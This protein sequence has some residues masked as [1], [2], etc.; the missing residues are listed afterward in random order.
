MIKFDILNRWTSEVQFTAEIECAE[1]ALRSVKI[2]LA[3]IWAVKS[4][5]NLYGANLSGA[6]LSRANLYGANLY[7]ANLY[8]ADLS[9]ANLS[10]ANLSRANLSRAN[11]YGANLSGA[12]LSGADLSRANLYGANLSRANLSR[13]N[14]YGA[15]LYGADLSGADLSRANL[16]G[17]DL[18]RAD[19][20][21]A[22]L[23]G[24]DL[25]RAGLYGADL[26]GAANAALAIAR[27]RILPEGDLIGWKKCKNNI[28]V[29]LR[30]P[31][32]ARRSH[33]FGRKCRAE[34]ADV[35]EVFGGEKGISLHDGKTEY[36]A[37]QRVK[38]DAFDDNWQ[39]E[40]SGGI[41]FYITKEEAEAHI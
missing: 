8:G 25:S 1:D 28:V 41:H 5:A 22:N 31:S 23:Y 24:A 6:D 14:L 29:K 9:G 26:S 30:I 20:S 21:R 36:L 4:R 10:G 17:A 16:Y 32:E 18:S 19:L 33:A 37:G 27:T 3:V 38:P 7:G 40:C 39:D 11:L 35:I 34:Y 13:A 15:N 12:D 2:G